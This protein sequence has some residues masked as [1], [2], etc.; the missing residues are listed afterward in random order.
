MRSGHAAR[1]VTIV[2]AAA[3]GAGI[4]WLLA[5]PDR[6]ALVSVAVFVAASAVGV[7]VA[8]L[9]VEDRSPVPPPAPPPPP[10]KPWPP[11]TDRRRPPDEWWTRPRP[12]PSPPAA[13]REP[14][15]TPGRSRSPISMAEPA[16]IVHRETAH[17]VLPVDG[18]AH[19]GPWPVP[20][21]PIRATAP[22]RPGAAELARYRESERIVQCPRCGSFRVEVTG[23]GS[24]PGD[25]L[26]FRCRADDHE[27][28]WRP[29]TAWP[30]TVVASR[31]NDR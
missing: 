31:R 18:H 24:R 16:P 1:T 22:G 29:G 23:I 28:T 30:A 10:P 12:L 7:L 4:G 15:P 25:E 2:V 9:L 20:T 17:L 13:G 8:A 21:D 5:F 26:A 19:P 27:W 6:P 3:I 14:V 11:E